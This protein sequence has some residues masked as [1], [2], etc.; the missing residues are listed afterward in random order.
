MSHNE[1]LFQW[2]GVVSRQM[3]HLSKPQAMTLAL[4]SFE[5]VMTRP[6]RAERLWLVMT[7]ATLR[8]VSVGGSYEAVY[9]CPTRLILR[10]TNSNI[11]AKINLANRL[12]MFCAFA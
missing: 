5:M 12:K 11:R 4:F 2:M 10:L 8:A 7:V 9:C 3:R 6:E 1:G